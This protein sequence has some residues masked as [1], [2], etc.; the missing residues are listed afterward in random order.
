MAVV[1]NETL[2][3]LSQAGKQLAEKLTALQIN[4]HSLQACRVEI[5]INGIDLCSWLNQQNHAVKIFWEDRAKEFSVAGIG[6]A[7]MVDAKDDKN[8]YSFINKI[9]STFSTDFPHLQYFGGF[10]FNSQHEPSA[11]W[12]NWGRGRF[13]LPQIEIRKIKNRTTLA[14]NILPLNYSAEALSSII[15]QLKQ[16]QNPQYSPIKSLTPPHSRKNIPGQQSWKTSAENIIK[17][18][19]QNKFKKVVLARSVRLDFNSPVNPFD[20]M[21]QLRATTSNCFCFIFQFQ[22]DESFIGA[23]PERLYRRTDR[24]IET[25]AV[26]GTRPRGRKDSEDSLFQNDLLSSHKDNKE[27]TYVVSMIQK[28]L[29][30]LCTKLQVDKSPSLLNWSAG[31]HLITHFH[32]HLKENI[33]DS[34]LLANLHPTPAVAGTPT[35]IALAEI[36]AMEG[37]DR[38]WYCGPIG[39]IGFN[40]SE[41]A[42]AIRCARLQNKSAYLYAGAGIIKESSPQSE[43]EETEN[44]LI[45]FLK[46]FNAA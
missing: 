24:T 45:N 9:Q 5:Q 6:A 29:E 22:Q 38:G 7:H 46:S 28:T 40:Q 10:C 17:A 37:F 25:E 42:V 21:S 4:S 23:S 35:A 41:F 1:V 31:H 16:L 12:R 30:P 15:Y 36:N 44:K 8:P 26:A 2:L 43:W 13:V 14:C 11:E 39:Y 34:A 27:Q 19:D 3:S 32:G 18:I 20:L 33:V